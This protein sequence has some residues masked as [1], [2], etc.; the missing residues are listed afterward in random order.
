MKP[1]TT[2]SHDRYR[3]A[4]CSDDRIYI[5]RIV[6]APQ[7]VTVFWKAPCEGPFR[8]LWRIKGGNDAW[9]AL[10][11]DKSYGVL[12][13][14]HDG[15]DF[16]FYVET[17]GYHSA[18]GYARPGAAPGTVV[19]Y[20]HPE[21]PKYAFSG[22]HLCSPSLLSHPDGYLLA[23]MDLFE[24][25]QPQNLTL[26]FRSDDKGE[27]WYHYSEVFPCFWG[28]L[29]LHRGEVYLLSASTEYGDL[30]IGRSTDGGKTFLPPT[31]LFRGSCHR[32]QAGWHRAPMPIVEWEGRLWTGIDYG[33]HMAGGHAS[34]LLSA[35]AEGDLTDPASWVMTDP[36]PYSPQWE[37]AVPGDDRGFIEG[38][39]VVLPDGGIGNMLRYFTARGTPSF[40]FAPILR[41]DVHTP[42]AA[43]T[44][45]KFVPFPGNL[46]K[47]EVRRDPV[48][49]RYYAI[50][51]R[52]TDPKTPAMRN[53]LSLMVSD[54]LTEWDL[55]C[56]L[57]DYRQED[58]RF[59]GFQYVSFLFDGNDLIYLSRTAVNEAQ[60]FHDNNYVTFHRLRDFR[61]ISE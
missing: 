21:D 53:L 57:L 20:L 8:L 39:A 38:N 16:E 48:T 12:A 42:E 3:P 24:G 27:T 45:E 60:S 56:D 30:L 41:G 40:G 18:V 15:A 61:K 1:A 50:L 31:V 36:L 2:W 26:I 54:D 14:L 29:F 55:V 4:V 9:C 33:A 23:S 59:V 11:T 58:P 13:P 49:Q 10:S 43:L 46:S 35:D 19:N 47:F 5:C 32:K 51:N 17:D 52:I 6:P 28:S 7:K 25:D 44:L 37:G 34:C 22:Q